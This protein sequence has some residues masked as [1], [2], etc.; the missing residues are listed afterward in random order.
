MNRR[1]WLLAA[2][3]VLAVLGVVVGIVASCGGGHTKA[4]A[5]TAVQTALVERGPLADLVS[6]DGILTYRA[7]P[8]G[9]PYA[10]INHA[11]GTF[12]QLPQGGDEIGCGGVL[13]RV[14]NRPVLLLCG[15]TPAYRSLTL[16]ERGPDVAE[17]NANLVRL[18][19]ANRKQPPATVDSF[20]SATSAALAR[21]QAKR[22]AGATG[23]LNLGDAVFL[24]E[25]VRIATLAAQ[26]GAPAQPGARVLEATS[27]TLEVQLSLDPSDQ[28]AVSR[29]D[30][31]RITLPDNSTVTGTVDRLRPIAASPSGQNSGSGGATIPAFIRIDRPQQIGALDQAPVHVDITTTGVQSAISVPV[32]AIVGKAGGGFG[33]EVL[34]PD[35][36]EELVVVK[37]GLFDTAGGRVQVDGDLHPGD[38]VVVP[39]S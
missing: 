38:H 33:V 37:L 34:R 2:A 18:G 14:D 16:G 27:D 3:A 36:R 25:P 20:S 30:R 1:S 15:P 9:S 28:G 8:N 12:T 7:Q 35:S 6:A 4:S 17:L 24:P 13:Y 26:L 39:A 5:R 10:V 23:S 21:L 31:A 19:Y 11:A 22:G 29:G 32:T